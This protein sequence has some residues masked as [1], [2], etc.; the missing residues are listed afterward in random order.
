MAFPR[1]LDK[2]WYMTRKPQAF[3][4]EKALKTLQIMLA[5]QDI[6]KMI[7]WAYKNDL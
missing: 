4:L 2:L 7:D 1:G 5:T 6:N 3:M